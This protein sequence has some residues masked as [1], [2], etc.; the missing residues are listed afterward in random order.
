MGL[1]VYEDR[2]CFWHVRALTKFQEKY[3]LIS[4]EANVNPVAV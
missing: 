4:T 2:S 3:C 1:L